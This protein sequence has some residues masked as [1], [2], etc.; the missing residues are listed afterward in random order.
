ML[1]CPKV[2]RIIVFVNKKNKKILKFFYTTFLSSKTRKKGQVK[3]LNKTPK[4]NRSST[5]L[6]LF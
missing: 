6:S 3:W 2:L 4:A 1:L 5:R